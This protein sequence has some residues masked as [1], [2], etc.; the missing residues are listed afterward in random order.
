MAVEL[1]HPVHRNRPI[2]VDSA[3]WYAGLLGTAFS[4]GR[5]VSFIPWKRTRHLPTMSVKRTLMMSLFLSAICSI[6]F[7]LSRSY[8]GALLARFCL[9][10]SNTLSGCVKRMAM[11]R[12]VKEASKLPQES[13]DENDQAGHRQV[14]MVPTIVLSV[15]MWGSALGPFVGGMLSNPGAYHED[16]ILPNQVEYRYPFFLPN[17]FGSLLC[18]ISLVG[19]TMFIPEERQEQMKRENTSMLPLST[20]PSTSE[21]RQTLLPVKIFKNDEQWKARDRM[22]HQLLKSNNFRLHF[23]AYWTFSFVVVCI[24]EAFPLFLIGRSSG[25]G[26]SP[27]EIGF[28]L[29]VAGFFSSFSQALSMEKILIWHD[30]DVESGFYPGLRTAALIANVPSVMIPL[31][32]LFNGG[33]YHQ[34]TEAA[35]RNNTDL[36]LDSDGQETSEASPGKISAG[37]FMFLT[38]L[39]VVLR[40]F[41]SSYFSMIGIATARIVP[42]SHRDEASRILTHG[43]LMARSVA[44]IVAGVVVSG[45]MAPPGGLMDAFRL[46]AVIGLGFGLGAAW[47]T[48]QLGPPH[49]HTPQ[50]RPERQKLNLSNRQRSQIHTRLW[51]VHYDDGYAT[52]ASNW[53]RIVR[54]V[55]IVNRLTHSNKRN[56]NKNSENR[57]SSGGLVKVN[58]VTKRMSSWVDHIFQPGIDLE[59]SKFLILGTSKYDPS[60]A[61]H[62]L[63]PP[64][65]ESLQKHLPWSCANENFWLR[66]TRNRDGDSIIAMDTKIRMAKNTIVAVETLRGDVFGCFMAEKWRKT[67]KY[68]PCGES[69]LWRMNCRKC[70]TSSTDEVIRQPEQT[71]DKPGRKVGDIEVYPWTGENDEC[72]LLSDERIGAGGGG[73]GFGFAIEDGLWRGSSCHCSTYDNP[74]LVTSPDGTFEIANI[75]VW[76]LTPFLFADEAEKSEASRRFISDNVDPNSVTSLWTKYI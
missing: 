67:G 50:E 38:L 18:V 60:C 26:F 33:T 2:T 51:E 42:S 14:E 61:P 62:V 46:W 12:A 68:E 75:E 41:S 24:D 13:N 64:L 6:W 28:I 37:S 8:I 15:M 20:Q 19:V 54:K 1:R 34:V 49:H 27:T 59:H 10:L 55:I 56:E 17:L 43:A 48:F 16:T 23:L 32:L 21:E 72:Q 39:M 71:C 47:F 11:D 31:V 30:R 45:F 29:S 35:M 3:G 4:A 5:Y 69:F 57:T 36:S 40:K 25:P 65:M 7:G 53:R 76:A 44:P 73:S 22:R 52:A 9:G 74:C 58:K 63:T 70:R 66:Y